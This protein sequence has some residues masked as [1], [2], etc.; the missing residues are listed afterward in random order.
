MVVTNHRSAD[1]F[2][3]NLI[4]PGKDPGSATGFTQLATGRFI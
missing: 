3:P 2:L 4:T 1:P